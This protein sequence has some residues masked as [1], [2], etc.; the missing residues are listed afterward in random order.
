MMT[1]PY[2]SPLSTGDRIPFRVGAWTVYPASD[3]IQCGDQITRLEP[4]VMEALILL[5]KH[6]GQVITREELEATVWAGSVVSYDAL[7]STILKLRK[8]FHDSTKNPQVVETV[9]KKGYRLIA[10]VGATSH[11]TG[12]IQ[13]GRREITW[14][15]PLSALLQLKYLAML[16]LLAIAIT[17][18][19]YMSN[20]FDNIKMDPTQAPSDKPSIAVLPFKNLGP[21]SSQDYFVDGISND[22][23]TVL[24]KLSG[25]FVISRDSSFVYKETNT[26]ITQIANTLQVQYILRGKVRRD[27]NRIR[28]YVLLTDTQ[29][30]NNIWAERYEANT[31]NIFELQDDITGKI[32]SALELKL[33]P[34]ER[35]GL[36]QARTANIA[37]YEYFLHGAEQFFHYART[38]NK[39]ARRFFEKAVELDPDFARAYAMLAWTFA[40]EFMNGWSADPET[41]LQS[42]EY[43]ATRALAL[44]NDLPIAH[45]VRGL[46]YRERGNYQKAL[47]DAEQAV[48]LDPNYANGHVLH[49][50]LLYYTG[51]PQEGLQKIKMAIRLNPYHPF[52][53][54]FHL[55]QA[56]F[57]L[58]RYQEAIAAF[59]DGLKSNPSSERL[60]V[61]LAASYAQAGQIEEAKWQMDQI[62]LVNPSI[63]LSGQKQ[64][65]PFKR[66]EDLENFLNGLSAA[67]LGE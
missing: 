37:A 9:P 7:T 3:R 29:T 1:T 42:G 60:R 41:S 23:I 53:Y 27:R 57:V 40:F 11:D 25:L 4:K 56:Y 59:K 54:P 65:F 5:A 55:G 30:G 63:S 33:T 8:A 28:I 35:Q 50:T 26:E 32:V 14:R 22:L 36:L 51:Q 62:R 48:K 24:T 10:E 39:E 67:G 66:R 6:P 38:S 43:L 58:K 16:V 34:A 44:N 20:Q 21:D 13:A 2:N 45:F 49:A 31:S 12:A 47:V 18:G 19:L 17:T 61:W 52:N 46:V 64:A 15:F